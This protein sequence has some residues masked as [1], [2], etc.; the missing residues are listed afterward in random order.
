MATTLALALLTVPATPAAADTGVAPRETAVIPESEPTVLPVEKILLAGASGF[1][2]QHNSSSNHHWTRYDTGATVQASGLNG[3]KSWDIRPAGG[4]AVS[5]WSRHPVDDVTRFGVYDLSDRT[6]DYW[7][8]PTEGTL[9][10]VFGRSILVRHPDM[11]LEI[12]TVGP[13]GTVTDTRPVTGLPAGSSYLDDARVGDATS[14]VVPAVGADGERWY[15]LLDIATARVVPIPG[16]APAAPTAFR[17]SGDTVAWIGSGT[18]RVHSRGGLVSGADTAARTATVAGAWSSAAV[19]GDRVV[20]LLDPASGA[21][22]GSV[23]TVGLD[24]TARTTVL[25]RAQAKDSLVQGPDGTALAVGGSTSR[26]WAVHR[27]AAGEPGPASVLPV[28]DPVENAGLTFRRGVVRHLQTQVLPS[29][30]ETH[31][32]LFNHTLAPDAAGAVPEQGGTLS[33]YSVRC[34]GEA[35]CVRVVDGAQDGTTYLREVNGQTMVSTR[36]V[37]DLSMVVPT[38]GARLVD[39]MDEYAVVDGGSPATQYVAHLA[40]TKILRTGPIRAAALWFDTLWTATGTN[41]QLQQLSLPGLTAQRTVSTGAACVPTEV[42]TSARWLWWSCGATGPAGVHDLHTGANLTVPAG[43][44]L[45]GDGFL[46]QHDTAAATLRMTAF[47]DGTVH[48]PVTLAS[49]ARGTATDSRGHSWAVDRQGR[50]VA[51]VDGDNAV[52]VVDTGVPGTAPGIGRAATNAGS[53]PRAATDDGRYWTGAFH[54][55]RPLSS[56]RVTVARKSTGEVV[57]QRTGGAA[58]DRLDVRWDG[59]LPS[60]AAAPSGGYR[61]TVHG[62]TEGASETTLGAGNLLVTC[63]SFAFRVVDCTGSPSLLGVKSTGAGHWYGDT[64]GGEP[65][66]ELLNNGWTD[67]WCLSCTGAERTSALVPFGDYDGDGYPDLLVR[68]GN[69][70][71][72]AHLGAGYMNYGLGK[73]ASLG[74]GWMMYRSIVAPGDVNGDGHHDILGID[75]DGKLW[76]YTTTGK[77]AINPRVQVGSGWN[78]YPRV[79]GAG[80]L[81]GDGHGD[82]LGIDST[83]VMYHYLSNGNTGWNARVKVYAGW[84]IYNSVV[85]IGDL[86]QDG[87]NDLVARDADG[88]LWYYAGLG[89]GSFAPRVQRGS[90]WNTYKI[91]I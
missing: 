67:N 76:L 75:T 61:W 19:L 18:V 8:R 79:T 11:R 6:W 47:H 71:M 78:I 16:A 55:T 25:P 70:G 82:L 27:F 64:N 49:L 46:V 90:G 45:L 84:N 91:I 10:G 59:R 68:D 30:G 2:H 77:G 37:G 50:G 13:E 35:R 1:L 80:D 31:F 74:A 83:G 23:V 9:F 34:P 87:R 28:R 72:K 85:P 36:R 48:A 66:G 5:V 57:A 42:Q 29:T 86:N 60:G 44:A 21:T 51:Y 54:P 14:V 56:W 17:L 53:N 38:T 43:P 89:N 65:T 7:P 39:A 73:T 62:T 40:E 3:Y 33:V 81:N 88:L 22:E 15:G 12:R 32:A 20:V 26:D 4:D 63:G 24:G 58:R 52:H 41:G 69:G